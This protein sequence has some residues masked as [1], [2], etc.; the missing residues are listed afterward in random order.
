MNNAIDLLLLNSSTGKQN[1]Q[2]TEV[3]SA[4]SAVELM[5][6]RYPFENHEQRELVTLEV[7]GDFQLKGRE[8]LCSMILINLMSN[9]LKAIHRAGKGRIHIIVDGTNDINQLTFSDTGCGISAAQLPH[10]FTRF[11][12]YPENSGTGIGLAFCKQVLDAWGASIQ[13]Y[14]IYNDSTRFVLSFPKTK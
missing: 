2:P 14:S 8:D 4:V 6:Q 3:I 7:L 5:L 9:A 13:C 11:Y 1:L 12:T 10:I